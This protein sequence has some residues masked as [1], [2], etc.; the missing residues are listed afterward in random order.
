MLHAPSIMI[1][2]TRDM[3]E[4][5]VHTHQ[6]TISAFKKRSHVRT[7]HMTAKWRQSRSEKR[8]ELRVINQ[9][10]SFKMEISCVSGWR[11]LVSQ[12]TSFIWTDRAPSALNAPLW[13]PIFVLHSHRVQFVYCCAAYPCIFSLSFEFTFFLLLVLFVLYFWSTYYS[14]ISPSGSVSPYCPY[15]VC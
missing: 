6:Y 13:E 12:V 1:Y 10:R 4:V 3:T 8:R 7:G 11:L 2:D 5:Q 9:A 15:P 14:H